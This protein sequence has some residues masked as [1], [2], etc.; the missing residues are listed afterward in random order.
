[1]N[2]RTGVGALCVCAVGDLNS[3]SLQTQLLEVDLS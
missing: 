3:V 1:M 2:V